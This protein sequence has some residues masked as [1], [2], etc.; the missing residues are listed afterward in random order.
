[1]GCFVDVGFFGMDTDETDGCFL[2]L[3]DT[4]LADD[5]D[6]TLFEVRNGL[7]LH[8]ALAMAQR[9]HKV[10]PTTGV[11]V[12][13]FDVDELKEKHITLYHGVTG[14]PSPGMREYVDLVGGV[15]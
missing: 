6:A 4:E 8:E 13:V 2:L 15:L 14:E 11:Q 1:M 7:Y 3:F 9:I 12:Q 5:A 10:A